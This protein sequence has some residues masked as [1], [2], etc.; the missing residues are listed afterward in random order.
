MVFP[1]TSSSVTVWSVPSPVPATHNGCPNTRIKQKGHGDL[2]EIIKGIVNEVGS[3][4]VSRHLLG[5]AVSTI[6]IWQ[7]ST[8]INLTNDMS[9]CLLLQLPRY[10]S[11]HFSV[12]TSWSHNTHI[13]A[14]H[15][16]STICGLSSG[17][18]PLVKVISTEN[19]CQCVRN[20]IWKGV[21]VR[22]QHIKGQKAM[23]IHAYPKIAFSG[24]KSPKSGTQH[25]FPEPISKYIP[26][27]M[28]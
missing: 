21:D 13:N 17:Q 14:I 18:R 28:K 1:I 3:L 23:H 7:Q 24:T 15:T 11:I 6:P 27:F 22:G 19:M 4:T 12:H 5:Q 26:T 25:N 2:R 9:A 16:Q 8:S 10:F 20:G